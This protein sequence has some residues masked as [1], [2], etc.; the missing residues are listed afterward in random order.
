MLF[1]IEKK[2]NMSKLRIFCLVLILLLAFHIHLASAQKLR[3][4]PPLYGI[5]AKTL[6]RGHWVFRGYAVF[7]HF[8]RM[9]NSKTGKMTSLPG[10]TE[11]TADS[12]ILKV[13]YGILN[14]FTA[15]VNLPYIHKRFKSLKIEKSGEGIGDVIGALLYKFYFNKTHRFL[16]SGLLFTKSP[17]G[18]ADDGHLALTKMPLGTGSFDAGFALMPEWGTGKWDLRWSAFYIARG[19]NKQHM[20]L[21]DVVSLSWSTAYNLNRRFIAESTF[22]Y[23][24]IARDRVN[25][26]YHLFQ[27]IPAL[28]YRLRRTFLVQWVV[29]VTV[30]ARVK[31]SA[32][33]ETW[34]GLYFLL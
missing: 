29:P 17:T 11:F 13:R 28:Q 4:R 31:F 18:K 27:F 7:P 30:D 3:P 23:K 22:L 26:S 12:Y 34:L 9:L 16:F 1:T 5:P 19:K 24:S 21:G 32:D 10:G 2:R 15:I 20:D 6:P 14:R 33:Y 25:P 8:T